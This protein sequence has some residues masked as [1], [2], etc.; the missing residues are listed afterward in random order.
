MKIRPHSDIH[1]EFDVKHG[2]RPW[3]PKPLEDDRNTVLML[4]GDLYHGDL[5]APHIARFAEDFLAVVIVLGNH[6]Y[7]DFAINNS[8][9]ENGAVL[10]LQESLDKL[11][12]LGRKVFV[13]DGTSV[14]IGDTVFIGT[15][16]WTSLN[17]AD[18]FTVNAARERMEDFKWI[19]IFESRDI[20]RRFTTEDW[21][22]AHR[23][24]SGS[25]FSEIRKHAGRKIVVATHHAPS[26]QS[27]DERYLN[28][29]TSGAYFTEYGNEI[30]SLP[31]IRL[32]AHGHVHSFKDYTIGSTRIICNPRGYPQH[33][34]QMMDELVVEV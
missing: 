19:S 27:I 5:S 29:S 3:R 25:I 6:D 16:F 28:G 12:L 34:S 15:T 4:Q 10:A 22:K 1:W 32:W 24:D 30:C 18:W 21:M 26:E 11:G 23:K 20:K 14:E 2:I 13:L 9:M 31:D 33:V 7:W 17:R 8:A